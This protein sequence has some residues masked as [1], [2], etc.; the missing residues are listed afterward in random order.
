MFQPIQEARVVEEIKQ[1]RHRLVFVAPGVSNAVS[2]ALV[3]QISQ[4]Q[5]LQVAVILDGDEECCR[6]GYC[7]A[8]ALGVLH[9]AAN[10]HGKPIRSQPGL[11]LCLLMSDERVLIWTPT[12]LI[13][14]APPGEGQPNGIVLESKTLEDLPAAVGLNAKSTGEL[15][16]IGKAPMEADA[17]QEVKA[18]IKAVPPAPFDLSRLSRVFSS[19]FQFIETTL[20]GAELTKREMR[21]DSLIL[22]SDAPEELRPLLHTTIQP[23][24]SDAD[25]TVDVPVLI[26]GELAYRANMQPHMKATKQADIHAYWDDLSKRYIVNMPGFGKIIRQTDKAKFQAECKAFEEVLELWVH[27]FKKQVESDHGTRVKRVVDL[28]VARMAGLSEKDRLSREVVEKLVKKGLDNLRVI[29]PGVKVIYKN[30]TVEST[31][32]S[33]F[34]EALKRV[35]PAEELK[36]WYSIFDAAPAVGLGR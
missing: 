1:A 30:F 18:A 26:N 6:L 15:P 33:E 32:D 10:D 8:E 12:P 34:L 3:A 29:E 2:Q 21:L 16:Q 27:G 9:A 11:R 13:F 14:E 19:K 36:N 5:S 35:I 28:I 23:F 4:N 22:N 20:K 31:R 25:K 17:V 7:E 24:N